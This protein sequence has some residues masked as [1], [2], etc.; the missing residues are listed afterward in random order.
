MITRLHGS[1]LCAKRVVHAH[2]SFEKQK[3]VQLWL[4]GMNTTGRVRRSE[5]WSCVTKQL[6]VHWKDWC[7]RWNSNT[8]ATSCKELTHWKRPWCWEGLGAGG[9]GD[10]GGWD[11][12]MDMSLCELRELVRE[13]WHAVIHGVTKSRTQLSYWTELK[14]LCDVKWATLVRFCICSE[15]FWIIWPKHFRFSRKFI[16]Y[17][18]MCEC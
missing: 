13:A 5:S 14:E 18:H 8:L 7:W 2:I 17:F 9:E 12:W 4:W 15:V 10:D 16:Y 3:W 6:C 1:L 11:G